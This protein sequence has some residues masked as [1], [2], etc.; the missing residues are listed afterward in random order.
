MYTNN[1]LDQTYWNDRWERGE[2]GWDI[3]YAAPAIT[4][5]ISSCTDKNASILI[6][7]CGNA[8]EAEWLAKEGFM[9]ITLID[10]AP[11]ATAQLQKK[12][13]HIPYIKVFCE[14]FFKHEGGY[15]III[16]Q[17]FFCAIPPSKRN[18]Y[19]QKTA[20][21]LHPKGKIIGLLFNKKFDHAGPPFGGSLDEYKMLFD[22]V[23]V[24][25]KMDPCYNSIP[26]RA[27]AEL[28]IHLEK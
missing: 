5:Y 23:F 8:Y 6:P 12:F 16:E 7:G 26:P 1:Y 19:V 2:T 11:K 24:I 25:H 17:T 27:G 4:K 28:F 20:S 18:E 14:D 15:D 22:P 9:N 21:L 3:G 10:I 13:Q